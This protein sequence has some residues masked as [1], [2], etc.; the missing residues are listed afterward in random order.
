MPRQKPPKDSHNFVF[1]FIDDMMGMFRSWIKSVGH[2]I[3]D[4]WWRAFLDW[5][6]NLHRPNDSATPSLDKLSDVLRKVLWGL[7]VLIG[8]LLAWLVWKNRRSFRRRGAV[9]RRAGGGG[10]RP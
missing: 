1:R 6:R 10:A 8:G 9:I 2:W 5:L 3:G 4:K 7:C